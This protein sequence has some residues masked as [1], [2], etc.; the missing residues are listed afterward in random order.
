M[1]HGFA[2][3]HGFARICYGLLFWQQSLT[4]VAEASFIQ[5][6]FLPKLDVQDGG[7]SIDLIGQD[8]G[9]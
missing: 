7:L 6:E 9:G 2:Q 1:I 3:L 8:F 5:E 4:M